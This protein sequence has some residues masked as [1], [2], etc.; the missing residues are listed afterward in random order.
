MLFPVWLLVFLPS[1][2]WLVLIPLNYII[3]RAVLKWSMGSMADKGLFCKKYTWKICLAGF[4]ADFAGS[5]LL[6]LVSGML[7]DYIDAAYDIVY[8]IEFDPLSNLAA[9]LITVAG[10]AVAAVCIYMFDKRIL[11]G[12]GLEAEQAKRSAICLAIIAAPY[13]Y[14]FPSELIYEGA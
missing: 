9:L 2:L 10:I 5:M 8:A 13:L 7:G 14:L 3:D 1:Y 11:L 12:A 6:F 4:L